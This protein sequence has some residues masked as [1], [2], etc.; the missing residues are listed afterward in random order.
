MRN[1][2]CVERVRVH[3]WFTD[4]PG[5]RFLIWRPRRRFCWM[6]FCEF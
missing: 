3:L 1:E 2:A 4:S 6:L 5:L